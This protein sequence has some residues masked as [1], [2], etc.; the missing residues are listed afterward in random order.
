[1]NE[2]IIEAVAPPAAT[3]PPK[4]CD[5]GLVLG[6]TIHE[7][8]QAAPDNEVTRAVVMSKIKQPIPP[9]LSEYAQIREWIEANIE[10]QVAKPK[11]LDGNRIAFRIPISITESESGTCSYRGTRTDSLDF[12][13][14]EHTILT[15]AEDCESFEEL[16]SALRDHIIENASNDGD[17]EEIDYDDYDSSGGNGN[18][19][20]FRE[21]MEE[22]V[23]EYLRDN[24]PDEYNRLMGID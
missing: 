18:E 1:M 3:P 8:L 4:K 16:V 22:V 5:I 19:I 10:Q 15:V 6:K 23:T 24:H 14:R 7:L 12:E 2:P 21:T 13:F 9:Q 17:L 20:F 11:A